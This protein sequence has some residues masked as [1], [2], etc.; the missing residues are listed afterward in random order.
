MKS[1]FRKRFERSSC[2][3]FLCSGVGFSL[4]DECQRILSPPRSSQLAFIHQESPLSR[5]INTPGTTSLSRRRPTRR[6]LIQSPFDSRSIPFSSP[7]RLIMAKA[8]DQEGAPPKV[9]ILRIEGPDSK[10]VVA[11]Y[12]QLLYGHGCNIIDAEQH[13]AEE[14]FF[15]RIVFDYGTMH[16]DRISLQTGINEVCSRFEMTSYLNWGESKKKIW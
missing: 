16:T 5:C 10:G 7:T 13:A 1:S 15:Q 14:R 8:A 9:A 2:L 4:R 11:A 3:F 12:A 6:V